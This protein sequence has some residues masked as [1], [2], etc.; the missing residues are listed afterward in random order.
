MASEYFSM[1]DYEAQKRYLKNLVIDGETVPDP[2]GI[3]KGLWLDDVTMWPN[4]EFGD[5]YTYLID[6]KGSFTKDKLNV[7]KSLQ[8]YNYFH[9]GYVHTAYYCA[10]CSNQLAILKTCV[11]PS[12]RSADP[13]YEAWV[14]LCKETTTLF[15]REVLNRLVIDYSGSR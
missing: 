13:N 9:N 6:T 7:C 2:Y 4:L 1:L 10:S 5:I 12:Q 14:V 15:T 11:N 3:A 8:A